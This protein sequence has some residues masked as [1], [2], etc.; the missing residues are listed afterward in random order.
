MS[1]E[2]IRLVTIGRILRRRRRLLAVIAVVGAL[3]GYGTSLLFPPRY[4]TSASVLLPGQWEERELLTQVDIA[5]S[6]AVVDRAAATLGWKGVSGGELLDRVSAKA[7]DGNIIK[8]SGTADTPE[9]AQQL[10]DRV[11]QEFVGFA[12]RIAGGGT[13]PEAATESE[14]LRQKVVETNRRITDLA[15]AAD[16]GQT[17]ES[18]QARTALEKLRTSLEEAMKKLDEADP[19][20]DKAG[21]VV[22]GPAARPTGE[23]PPTRMQLIVAGAVLFFL[24]AVIGHLAAARMNRRLRTEPEIAAALGSAL[25]GTVDVPGEWPAHRS[26][27]RGPQAW[28]RRLL[29]VDTRWDLPTPRRP[30]DEAD[31]RIR[32]RRVCA[33]LRDQLPAPRR[34]LVVVPDGDEIARR[35][36]GQLVAE[37]KSDPLLRVVEVSVDRPMVPD[38]DTESGALVVLSV[39]SRTAEEL[40]GI[41]EACADAGHAVVGIVV[42]G[43]VRARPT[44][45]AGRSSDEATLALAVRGHATGGSV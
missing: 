34:L 11:A 39:G 38:R 22:M 14:A 17:V 18:V 30:G 3:V 10:S 6:S 2:T 29:G 32:Y 5:T 31:R 27:G 16:P 21:M 37:A 9:R 26:E 1:E 42:A 8:I 43:T 44:R 7:A 40:A 41:A 45:T 19:A 33:R 23:A 20:T 35:A 13:D 25:L 15:N 36:A 4:T 24:L 12:A 28:I